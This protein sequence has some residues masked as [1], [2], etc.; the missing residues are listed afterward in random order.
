[1][2]AELGLDE[3]KLY[4]E[5]VRAVERHDVS[6]EVDRLRSHAVMAGDLLA[7]P[8]PAGKRLDF[9]AQEMMREA[10][11]IGSKSASAA[12]AQETVALKSEIEKLRE[13]VQNV[14]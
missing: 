5:V 9:L 14:E 7:A 1:M 10:N 12:L 13:Q 6:E 8:E 11:T 4:Q 2:Q 3:G